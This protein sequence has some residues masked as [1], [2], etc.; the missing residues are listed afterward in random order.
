[1]SDIKVIGFSFSKIFVEKISS[2]FKDLKIDRNIKIESVE[3][4]KPQALQIK[5][6]LLEIKFKY[7]ISYDPNVA[8]FEFSGNLLVTADQK[9]A[10][11]FLS[12]WKEKKFPER[13]KIVLFNIIMR[14][15]D[16]KAMEIEDEMGLPL[17]VAL[18]LIR[19]KKD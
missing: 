2:E 4:I 6:D 12:E 3:K 14:K 15:S 13:H 9:V 7:G 17:H 16:I 11:E 19:E 8:K 18:P 5:E 1:M 10:K